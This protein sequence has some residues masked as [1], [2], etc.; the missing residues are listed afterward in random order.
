MHRDSRDTTANDA[1]VAGTIQVTSDQCVEP[2]T[3]GPN[4][5]IDWLNCGL[6]GAGWTP[7]HITVD[8]MIVKDLSEALKDPNTPFKAC[9]AYEDMF[10]KHASEFGLKPIMLAAFAM[11]ESTCN[12]ATGLMQLTEDKCGEAP[13]GDCRDPD[14]NI[15]TGAK[16]F[17]DTLSGNGGS[18]LVSIGEYNGWSPGLTQEKATA[19][20]DSS[21]CRCQN[22]LDYLHQYMN[23]WL[24]NIDAYA[25]NL[26]KY[27]NLD[28]CADK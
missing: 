25:A 5:E 11:Q 7:P 12:P 4:G 28:G 3:S 10:N 19:A 24:Q 15:R 8:D 26:G 20:R 23:G 21:C 2:H 18:V 16:Y 27:H 22:N 1:T 13:G 6:T 17:A 9:A 14:Y